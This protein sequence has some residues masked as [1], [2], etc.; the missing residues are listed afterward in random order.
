MAEHLYD[1]VVAGAG[2]AG[3]AAACVLSQAGLD[4]VILEGRARVGGRAFTRPFAGTSA[5]AE[6]GGS[7]IAPWHHR[8]RHYVGVSEFRLRP[9]EPVRER[10]WHDGERLL[11]DGPAAPDDMDAYQAG[12][13]RVRA[14]VRS[15]ATGHKKDQFGLPLV[16]VSM[17]GYLH[18]IG[19]SLPL[20]AQLLAWWCI[21]G[22]GNP[23]RISAAEFLSSCAHGNGTPEGMMESL[24]HTIEPGAQDLVESI[25]GLSGATLLCNAP[26]EDLRQFRSDVLVGCGNGEK[27]RARA[28]IIALPLNALKTV[29]FAPALER[30]KMQALG[31]GHGGRAFKLWI[32]VR[33]VGLGMLATGGLSGLQ[34]MFAERESEVGTILLVGF[35]LFDGHFDP[36]S[37]R[38]VEKGVRQFFPEAEILRSDWHD[39]VGDPFSRGTWLALP[40][41][42][43]W[44]G[45]ATEWQSEGRIFHASADFAPG[46]PGWFESA[47]ESGEAAARQLLLQFAGA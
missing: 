13:A 15:L 3:A 22:N 19:A 1:V 21:S 18:R 2:F 5:R 23:N 33:D 24:G 20:R 40:A 11:S 47:I 45:D 27:Y 34:W 12:L 29:R 43:A 8:I 31:L 6:F 17:S 16:D 32:E 7:W 9:T 28:A 35:G 26:V 46:M 36:G 44:I 4:V 42:A 37:A 39:W 41:D 38:D 25:I 14:D 30:R 10:R